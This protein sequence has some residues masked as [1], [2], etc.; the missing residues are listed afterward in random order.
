M[1]T[2]ERRRE[3]SDVLRPATPPR[4]IDNVYTEDQRERL[5]DV[6]RTEGPWQLIIAQH[7]DQANRIIN[8]IIIPYILGF[9]ACFA[10]TNHPLIIP[11]RSNT[12]F[13]QAFGYQFISI[14]IYIRLRVV[15][16]T[17]SRTVICN[18]NNYRYFTGCVLGHGQRAAD[19]SG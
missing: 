18:D 16:I 4:E 1:L 6:A 2:D 9:I 7:F 10:F 15:A 17:V 13:S 14:I 19:R 11:N 8:I 3:L 5:L 12:V